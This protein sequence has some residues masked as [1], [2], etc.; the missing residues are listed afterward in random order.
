MEEVIL[1]VLEGR[2]H[3]AARGGRLHDAGARVGAA[4]GRGA[5]QSLE[6]FLLTARRNL[7]PLDLNQR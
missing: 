2:V 6:P 4:A 5:T 3:P 1:Y 7:R